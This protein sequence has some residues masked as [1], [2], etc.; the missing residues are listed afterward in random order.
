MNRKLLLL[1]LYL[2]PSLF[3]NA[4]V[5]PNGVATIDISD[6]IAGQYLS[7]LMKVLKT[8]SDGSSIILLHESV[9]LI[10]KD[11]NVVKK[12]NL[13]LESK[14]KKCD[15]VGNSISEKDLH[16]IYRQKTQKGI[17]IKSFSIDLVTLKVDRKVNSI[18][19]IDSRKESNNFKSDVNFIKSPDGEFQSFVVRPT[20]K[21]S[22]KQKAVPFIVIN[23]DKE[24]KV[25]NKTTSY[26]KI[27]A[28]TSNEV[29]I[30]DFG[31]IFYLANKYRGLEYFKTKPEETILYHYNPK[32]KRL[33][34]EV[35]SINNKSI[36]NISMTLDYDG[37]LILLGLAGMVKQGKGGLKNFFYQKYLVE[38]NKLNKLEKSSISSEFKNA[39]THFK[40]ESKVFSK[41]FDLE[42]YK[43]DSIV[44][45][46]NGNLLAFGEK[47][48]SLATGQNGVAYLYFNLFGVEF[49]TEGEVVKQINIPKAQKGARIPKY[50]SYIPMFIDDDIYFVYN[51]SPEG[52]NRLHT[53][54]GT[55]AVNVP[56]VAKLSEG[57][58]VKEVL[59][60]YNKNTEVMITGA[61]YYTNFETG[62]ILLK[63]DSGEGLK[64]GKISFK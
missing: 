39:D 62:E 21:F 59:F 45:L 63:I 42:H 40:G 31:N 47:R 25:I 52:P 18:G 13:N 14:C 32:S 43:I 44:T 50:S 15:Y 54:I 28:Y 35:I 57:S 16:I 30:D 34:E 23:V 51:E 46:S 61:E 10:D 6:R 33:I 55:N 1:V 36:K 29:L 26:P 22:W 20:S 11:F 41:S 53:G 8:N 64:I 3:I 58:P 4:Q 38:Y 5:N 17:E 19:E 60:D 24:L 48:Y 7:D 9:L 2:I 56:V 27:P 49:N 12:S 37:N